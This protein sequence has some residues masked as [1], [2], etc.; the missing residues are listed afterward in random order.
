MIA[1]APIE[2]A[3]PDD[4]AA[5][6]ALSRDSIEHGLPWRW[7]PSRV[8]RAIR[9]PDT[10][11]AVVREQGQL[12]AFGIMGYTDEDAHLLL[13]AVR[14]ERRRAGLASALLAWLEDVARSAG[15]VRIRVEARL[16]NPEARCFYNEHGYHE[17]AI[18]RGMYGGAVDG[19]LLEKWLRVQGHAPAA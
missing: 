12:A 18:R 7:T 14:P 8:L 16:P 6:A 4:A 19:V 17:R 15:A 5:I 11:V 1:D 13:L 9:H 2:L 3:L 10:N